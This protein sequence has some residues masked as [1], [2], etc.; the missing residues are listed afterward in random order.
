MD[1]REG[2]SNSSIVRRRALLYGLLVAVLLLGAYPAHRAICRGNAELHTL[3]ETISSLLALTAAALALVRFYAKKD[4][5]FLLLGT[6][7]LGTGTIDAYHALITSSFLAG[8]T[9]SALSALTPWNGTASRAFMSLLMCATLISWKR[10][11]SQPAA[12]RVREGAVYALVGLWAVSSFLFFAFVPLP[13]PEYA[14]FIVRRP[15]EMVSALFFSRGVLG[16]LWKGEWKTDAFEHCLVLSLIAAAAGEFAYMSFYNHL[17]D[18]QFF[19][20]HALKILVYSF[21]IVGLFRN[22]FLIFQR[23]AENAT[24]L[25]VRVRERTEE[26]SRT[27]EKLAEEIVEREGTE[28]KLQQAI[29]SA[30]AASEAK[31]EFLANMSH[32]IRTPLKG[33]IGM[34]ELAMD[35]ELTAAR[36]VG[37]SFAR[38]LAWMVLAWWS[39]SGKIRSCPTAAIM[40]L[41]SAGLRGDIARCCLLAEA[42]PP[43]RTAGGNI[44]SA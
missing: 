20:G 27:N 10:E 4:T 34:T 42:G 44:Q 2:K 28:A 40:M 15:L 8:Y 16:Y 33:V 32:E 3:L 36:Q 18:A 9:P 26:L 39:A 41:T 11:A 37:R 6:C 1:V 13:P 22:T 29:S 43:L 17:Y 31:S 23:E 30:L 14:N 7:F 35:T 12:G 5:S 19:A 21:V 24:L 38:C 25:E